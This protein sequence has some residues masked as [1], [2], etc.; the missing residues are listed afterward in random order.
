MLIKQVAALCLLI[1]LQDAATQLRLLSHTANYFQNSKSC[2]KTNQV[3]KFPPKA[4]L[5]TLVFNGSHFNM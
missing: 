5:D 1:N 2:F 3:N 4:I